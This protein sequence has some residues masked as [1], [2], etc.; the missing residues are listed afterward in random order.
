[1]SRSR[2]NA[3]STGCTAPCF[4]THF[5]RTVTSVTDDNELGRFLRAQRARI[6][7]ADVGL[8]LLGSR[9]VAGLRREEVAVR[10]GVSAESYARLEQ[11]RVRAPSAQMMD[12]ICGALRMGNDSRGHAYRLARLADAATQLAVEEVSV[13]L[14]QMLDDLPNAAAYVVNPASR[15]VASNRV[16]AALI[17]PE[18]YDQPLPYLFSDPAAYSY[19]IDWDRVARA[20]VSGLRLAAKYIPRH[21][22]VTALIAQLRLLDAFAALWDDREVAGLTIIHKAINHPDVGRIDLSYQTFDVRDVPGQQLVVA[23]ARAGS[24]SA[25]A[26]TLLGTLDATRTSE[27]PESKNGLL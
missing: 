23:T 25:D 3:E 6:T 16:A 12:A 22:E 5:R 11:G 17:G 18:Q 1:M 15:V 24:P 13:E 7:P 2:E 4:G 27:H 21:P 9:R 20:A 19:F 8:P 26:L 10:A 14:R